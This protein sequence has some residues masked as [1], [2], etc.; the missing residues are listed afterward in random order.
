MRILRGWTA[1]ALAWLP[2]AI[3]YGVAIAT[4][5]D[6]STLW[7]GILSGCVLMGAGALGGVLVWR[8][9]GRVPYPGK[10]SAR[11]L[12]IH[13][14]AALLYSAAWF[15]SLLGWLLLVAGSYVA[16]IVL[17]QAGIWQ[18][19]T[20]LYVYGLIAGFSYLLR[21]QK[22]LREREAAAAR[23]QAAAAR[24]QLQAVRAQLNPHFLFN[25]L[26]A[27]S[28]LVRTDAAAADR[29]LERLGELLRRTLDH[30]QHDLVPLDEEWSFVR[31]YL[32]LEQL[33]LGKRLRLELSMDP[34]ALAVQVPP[35]VLQ[36]LVENAVQHGVAGRP[37][38]GV[39]QVSALR[40]NGVLTLRVSDDGPGAL[41]E[42]ASTS[43]GF[44]LEGVRQQLQ[45]RF[46]ERAQFKVETAP[47][48]G[49]AVTITL[50]AEN[51]IDS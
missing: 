6:G 37:E 17:R 11:F 39:V 41:A 14:L 33:R 43:G 4:Q 51:A 16:G 9:S 29:A 40:R 18:F 42:A 46:G 30:T 12:G 15:G 26:H 31:G 27:V 34:A 44:G 19:L 28:A 49:F 38:G 24:A 5:P 8:L 32:E 48:A 50:P 2:P 25:A 21:T 1:Y 47:N 45:G 36:P 23:A 3:L 13:V 35:L 10:P 22:H 7:Q 20:G